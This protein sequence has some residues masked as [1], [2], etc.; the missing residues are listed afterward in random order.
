M[1]R[2]ALELSIICLFFA[3]YNFFGTELATA[4]NQ[5]QQLLNE[6]VAEVGP[7]KITYETL[8]KAFQKNMN[9]KD[10]ELYEIPK[11]SI[12]DFL[13][14]YIN[15]RL[16]VID[17]ID[18]GFDKDSSVLED[19][20]Q[21]RKILAETYFFEKTLLNPWIEKM[22][23]RRD[24]EYKIAIIVFAF[25]AEPNPDTLATY[26]KAKACIDLLKKGHSFHQ[27]AID[28]SDDKE[29]GKNGGVVSTWI[30]SGNVQR[31]L[32]N[33]IFSLDVGNYYPELISTRYG[34]FIIKLLDKQPRKFVKASHILITDD[35][36]DSTYADEIADEIIQKLKSGE[37]F[38]ELA[39]RYSKDLATSAKG[40]IMDNFYSR[41]TGYENTNSRLVPEFEKGLFD[42]KDSEISDKVESMY[43]VHIIRRDSTKNY[44]PE[45][46]AKDLKIIYKKSYYE[47][48]KKDFIDS[49]KTAY[50]FKI[51]HDMLEKLI[52]TSDTTKTN[53]DENWAQQISKELYPEIVFELLGQKTSVG[54]F[55]VMLSQNSKLRGLGLNK[56]GMIK[57][58][59]KITTPIIMNEATK[60]LEEQYPEFAALMKEFRDGILLF[61]VE[62][63]EVWDK[64]KFDSTKARAYWDTTKSRYKTSPKY[65]FSEIF[66]LTD[67]LAQNIYNKIKKGADFEEMAEKHTQR[68]GYREKKGYW[69]AFTD[70]ENDLAKIIKEKN[71]KEGTILE[72]VKYKKGYSIIKFNKFL[73]VRQ[74]TFEEAI[75]DFAPQFQDIMQKELLNNWLTRVKQKFPV[76]VYEKK[77][78]KIIKTSTK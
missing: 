9:R 48:D 21:N 55:I 74:K 61:K 8:Q 34:Y 33:A 77:I 12:I 70:E 76:K 10:V 3:F 66:V 63:M 49:L 71:V 51:H 41:S 16:K 40:G 18:R 5:K 45:I 4:K 44:D 20:E 42:L 59:N 25:P 60:N 27:I 24:Q 19:I 78:D 75:P 26:K 68:N 7:E 23:E 47:K 14:L 69:G 11:D 38:E 13:N 62:Q 29:T 46:E 72:P 54:E 36:E 28:S 57:A 53:L 1:K 52:K 32:E 64:L 2:L 17:A 15:Y 65:D 56:S 37:K 50:G 58:I 30:T 73:P 31:P 6:V 67:S 22:L 35:P 39:K 43:G